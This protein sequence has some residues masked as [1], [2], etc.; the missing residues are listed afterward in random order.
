MPT[1]TSDENQVSDDPKVFWS[2]RPTAVG[3]I[4]TFRRKPRFRYSMEF[5][6]LN[7]RAPQGYSCH[8][9]NTI[10]DFVMWINLGRQIQLV[11]CAL[12]EDGVGPHAGTQSG[13]CEVESTADRD[14]LKGMFYSRH[15]VK[16]F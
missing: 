8:R 7:S 10:D 1:Y 6:L 9:F 15:L 5:C 11:G 14:S 2:T 16:V 12:L 4:V 3:I 13:F